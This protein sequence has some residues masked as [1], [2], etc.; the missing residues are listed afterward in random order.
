MNEGLKSA[1]RWTYPI[2]PR[3]SDFIFGGIHQILKQQYLG[4]INF[5][6]KPRHIRPLSLMFSYSGEQEIDKLILEGEKAVWENASRIENSVK[7]GRTIKKSL[8][9]YET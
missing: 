5:V 2:A 7:I 8:A 4:D 1:R 9:M 6:L 3:K